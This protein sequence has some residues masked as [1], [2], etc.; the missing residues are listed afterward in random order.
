M[1]TSFTLF[2]MAFI[3]PGAIQ[4]LLAWATT[5][6]EFSSRRKYNVFIGMVLVFGWV[7]TFAAV[8]LLLLSVY[9][10]PFSRE[11]STSAV[12]SSATRWS[13]L[14]AIAVLSICSFLVLEANGVVLWKNGWGFFLNVHVHNHPRKEKKA[15]DFFPFVICTCPTTLRFSISC[16]VLAT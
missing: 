13:S 7:S 11:G 16:Q 4:G 5:R 9:F 6:T 2:C 3:L 1:S 8:Y 12:F 10:L 14:G 15:T